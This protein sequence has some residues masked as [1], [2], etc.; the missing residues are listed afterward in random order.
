MWNLRNV[1]RFFGRCLWI[2]FIAKS[3]DWIATSKI[4][5]STRNRMTSQWNIQFGWRY[6]TIKHSV[7]CRPLSRFAFN[8]SLRQIEGT[9]EFRW[10]PNDSDGLLMSF[11]RRFVWFN[12]W[13]FNGFCVFELAGQAYASIQMRES[14]GNMACQIHVRNSALHSIECYLFNNAKHS[15]VFSVLLSSKVVRLDTVH[16]NALPIS[17]QFAQNWLFLFDCAC[18]WR[19]CT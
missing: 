9:L 18:I 13:W 12:R 14:V 19:R 2:E 3:V 6:R 5:W 15:D 16:T 4:E 8:Y 11:G 1:W 7:R 17:K 10:L